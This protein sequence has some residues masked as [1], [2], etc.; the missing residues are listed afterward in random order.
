M[1]LP[2]WKPPHKSPIVTIISYILKGNVNLKDHLGREAGLQNS[3]L[4]NR[5]RIRG[6]YARVSKHI[7]VTPNEYQKSNYV[8]TAVIEGKKMPLPGEISKVTSWHI[9][10]VSRGHSTY[11]KRGV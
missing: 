6:I 4:T 5:N 10:E 1:S 2:L 7:I 9:G 8:D 11:G 3:V